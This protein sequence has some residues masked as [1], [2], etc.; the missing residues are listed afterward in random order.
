MMPT[1]A[2]ASF[3]LDPASRLRL[4]I[5]TFKLAVVVSVSVALAFHRNYPLLGTIWFLCFWH[6]VFAGIAAVAQRHKH[7]A[8][9]LTAWD[10][11][12]AFLGLA[13]LMRIVDTVVE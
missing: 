5:F 4:R 9:F 13:V 10:E 1:T 3:S 7:N 11:M 2:G 8:A 12:A 6:S